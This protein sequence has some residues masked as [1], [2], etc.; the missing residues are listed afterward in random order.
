M[1][2][3]MVTAVR[4]PKQKRRT[5][6]SVSGLC[7]V[8]VSNRQEAYLLLGAGALPSSVF[9]FLPF[10]LVGAGASSAKEMET[11]PNASDRPNINVISL[12]ILCVILLFDFSDDCLAQVR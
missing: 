11:A 1:N 7:G 12:L 9:F 3:V 6:H 8:S 2:F 5:G 4:A 10:F